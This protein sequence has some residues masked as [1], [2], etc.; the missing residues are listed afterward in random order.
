MK[1]KTFSDGPIDNESALG[2]LMA[3]CQ[4]GNTPLLEA[5]LSKFCDTVGL[6]FP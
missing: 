2:Q 3:L 1:K 5:I 6:A 4:T